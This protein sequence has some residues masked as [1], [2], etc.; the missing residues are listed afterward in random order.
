MYSY[1]VDFRVF[2]QLSIPEHCY[3]SFTDVLVRPT[4]LKVMLN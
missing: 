2:H 1:E 3:F 4:K